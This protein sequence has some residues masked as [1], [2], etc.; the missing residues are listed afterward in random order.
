MSHTKHTT[1]NRDYFT[2]KQWQLLGN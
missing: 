2:D 1:G